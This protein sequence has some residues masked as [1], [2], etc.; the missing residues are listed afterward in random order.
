MLDDFLKRVVEKLPDK[1]MDS[2][3]VVFTGRR[4]AYFLYG[5]LRGKGIVFPPKVFTLSEFFYS[6]LSDFLPYYRANTLDLF[7]YLKISAQKHISDFSSSLI[8][9]HQ[10]DSVF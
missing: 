9:S 2:Y 3:Y 8:K 10:S 5:Y 4:P 6:I 1:A 7:H